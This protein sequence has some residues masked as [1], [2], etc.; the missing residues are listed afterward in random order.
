M[1]DFT[2][3]SGV[4][5]NRSAIF[6]VNPT[7]CP[8]AK[9]DLF[10]FQHVTNGISSTNTCSL[11]DSNVAFGDGLGSVSFHANQIYDGHHVGVD[12]LNICESKCSSIVQPDVVS[13]NLDQLIIG[14]ECRGEEQGMS[15]ASDV[16]LLGNGVMA[17]SQTSQSSCF[18]GN[19]GKEIFS[20]L[21]SHPAGSADVSI[22][23]T[24]TNTFDPFKSAQVSCLSE[25][26]HWSFCS[27][28][29]E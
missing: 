23:E 1:D 6:E 26:H 15:S 22:S 21:P 18:I 4:L 13:S 27:F 12:L 3:F 5:H 28:N 14:K 24:L 25:Q 20:S 9:P 2:D 17:P 11:S 19:A 7:A 29:H 8:L 10:N 16:D